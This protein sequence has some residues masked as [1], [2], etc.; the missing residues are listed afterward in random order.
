[1]LHHDRRVSRKGPSV[2]QENKQNL[3]V[4]GSKTIVDKKTSLQFLIDF[5]L[6]WVHAKKI[7]DFE[8]NR[9]GKTAAVPWTVRF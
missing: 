3:K 9:G 5:I 8:F 1:M 2:Q 4:K 6:K 7:K